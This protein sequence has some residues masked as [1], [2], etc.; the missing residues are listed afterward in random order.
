MSF[1]RNPHKGWENEHLA[2]F[3]LSRISFVSNPVTVADDV[4]SDFFC[5]LFEVGERDTLFPRS[6]FA[7]QVKSSKDRID[8][9]GKIKYFEKLELPFF[10]G[11]I[12]QKHLRL[13]IYSGEYLP[14]FFSH[15]GIPQDLKLSLED[16]PVTFENYCEVRPE[17]K[18]ILRM[19]HLLDLEAQEDKDAIV[20][21][22]RCLI[23]LCFR[24]LQNISSRHNC[25]YV[26][27][28]GND[29]VAIFAGPGSAQ[30]FRNNF[31]YR[32]AEAF[33][34]FE[35]LYKS[36]PQQF[37]I[38]EYRTYERSYLDL[39]EKTDQIPSLVEE[40]YQRIK[41]LLT[42]TEIDG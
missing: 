30:T 6:S 22:G 17:G 4:G 5:T 1:L 13:S 19:P 16:T 42:N 3:L 38:T 28:L 25:E 2:L 26:F 27:H 11:V 23:Q 15:Y 36:S 20:D 9:T 34:N 24:M 41:Q 14:I 21:K 18:Y 35:W 8:P 37:P 7:I 40:M 31:Y 39:K 32:L 29:R 33:C 10:V 12:D